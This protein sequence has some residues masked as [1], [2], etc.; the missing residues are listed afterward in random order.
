MDI[1]G[2]HA[3]LAIDIEKCRLSSAG[4]FTSGSFDDPPVR[5]QL[6]DN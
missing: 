6:F 3:A 1:E 5:E 4:D 2:K